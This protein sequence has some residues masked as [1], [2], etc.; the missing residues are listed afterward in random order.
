MAY[1]RKVQGVRNFFFNFVRGG[2]GDILSLV[3]HGGGTKR[4][5][6]LGVTLM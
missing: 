3:S 1:N 6:L 5:N 4:E 2:G